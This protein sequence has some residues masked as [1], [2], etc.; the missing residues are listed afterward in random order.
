[1]SSRDPICWMF[2]G[3]NRKGKTTLLLEYMARFRAAKRWGKIATFEQNNSIKRSLYNTKVDRENYKQLFLSATDTLFIIDDY[4]MLFPQDRP[5]DFWHKFYGARAS[6]N[7]DVIFTCHAPAQVMGYLDDY[8]ETYFLWHTISGRKF[9]K[10]ISCAD[11]L[12]EAK[13]KVDKY[14]EKFNH[15]QYRNLYPNFP[16]AIINKTNNSKLPIGISYYNIK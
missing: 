6:N 16:Y 1:M 5:E 3:L 13:I 4:K 14:A 9:D 11:W 12:E 8:I 2:C 15:D 10:K 7:N